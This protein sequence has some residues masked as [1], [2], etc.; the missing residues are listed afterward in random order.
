MTILEAILLR[1][2]L[3]F[4][5]LGSCVGLIVGALLI[6]RP[7]W[8]ARVNLFA[9]RWVST[10]A[11]NKTME[12]TIEFDR[13]FYRYRRFSGGVTM[14]GALY[15][16]YFFTVQLD[17]AAAIAG[18]SRHFH[19][20]AAAVA[21]L[22]DPLVLIVLLGA[23]FA[24]FVSLFVLFRPSQLR[25]FERGANQ[26]ISL[27]RSLKPLEIPRSGVDEFAL[28]HAPKTGIMLVMGSLYTLVLLTFWIK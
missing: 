10:R 18:L 19:L 8:L 12:Q 17:K 15:L 14:L 11:L 16:L 1:A 2:F 9:N 22:F 23:V 25:E 3:Y 27:R 5:I 21:A 4:L 7:H 26:W 28:R 24:L 13:W 6:L 20:P